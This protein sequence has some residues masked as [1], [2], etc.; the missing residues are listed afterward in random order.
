[1]QNSNIKKWLS[2]G[3][4]IAAGAL[5]CGQASA[6]ALSFTAISTPFNSPI[7]IDYY[8]PTDEVILSV[9]YP[10]GG[11]NNFELVSATGTRTTFSSISGL[12]DEVKIATA[13]STSNGGFSDGSDIPV[14]TF[15]SGTGVGGQLLRVE[16][17][18]GSSTTIATGASGLFRG[19]MYVDRTG[20]FDGDLVAVSTGGTVIR[21][22]EN[23]NVSILANI[24]VHLEGVMVV[25]DDPSWGDLAGKII[26]GAEGGG[27]M[28]AID[29][30]GVVESYQNIGVA[31]EDIDMIVGNENFFGVNFGTSRLLG[32]EA[33]AFAN[34]VGKIL[35]TQE[36]V[37]GGT[38]GLFTLEWDAGSS[39]LLIEAVTLIGGGA[40]VAQ[41]EHVTFAPAGVVEI[42]SVPGPAALWLALTGLA[43]LF[44]SRRRVLAR[45]RLIS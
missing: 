17:G 11:P 45:R 36:S 31:I 12:T 8:E 19:S 13:R 29:V 18:G 27:D 7:G 34:D 33:S 23:N 5:W 41:W 44:A 15:Y 32:V 39:G 26:A 20:V 43:A 4:A 1:M 14:G 40:P 22:D 6:L 28:Y 30:N 9:N 25:P 2:G 35:L 3:A 38:T 24:G 16:A 10:S 21:V 42:P 37:G